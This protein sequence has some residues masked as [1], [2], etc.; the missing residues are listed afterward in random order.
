LALAFLKKFHDS[1]M[2]T[3]LSLILS[4][5]CKNC[6][7]YF[8]RFI[9]HGSWLI[10]KKGTGNREQGTEDRRKQPSRK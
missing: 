4:Y 5:G 6:K 10:A 7:P 3:I 8:V 2:L 1:A 9:V